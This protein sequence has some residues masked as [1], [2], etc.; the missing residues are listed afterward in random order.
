MKTPLI[1]LTTVLSISAKAQ[2]SASFGLGM[3]TIPA[4]PVVAI[5]ADI[6]LN[7]LVL[8]P[9]IIADVANTEP[10]NFGV[11]AGYEYGVSETVKLRAGAG[12]FYQLY[13]TDAYDK[14]RNT[15]TGNCFLSAQYKKIYGQAEY[16]GCLR[17][18]IGIRTA[19]FNQ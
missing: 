1:I 14:E 18:S 11:K 16:M 19:I 13:S 15:F 5:G 4:S 2:V 6:K 8:T 10:A 17:L 7:S 3:K 12:I 9:E